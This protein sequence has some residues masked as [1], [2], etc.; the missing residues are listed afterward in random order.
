MN[1]TNK[2]IC[3]HGHFYQPPRENAWLEVVELQD[4][5]QPFHDWNDRINFECYAPN[6]AARILDEK[7]FIKK[8]INNYTRISFNFG[9]TLLSWMEKADPETYREILKADQIS[10]TKFSGHGSAIAQVHSHLILPLANRADK[11]TQVIWGIKDFE[12]RFGRKPE[13]MWLAETAANLESLEVL[14]ENDIRYTILSPR[15]AKSIRKIGSSKWKDGLDTRRPYLVKL[16]SGKTMIVFFYDGS[17]AQ[18]V[19]FDG[20]LNNGKGFASRFINTFDDDDTPQLAHVATDGESY[21]HHHRYGEMALADCIDYIEKNNLAT[22][23]NY[24]EY[25]DK[26]PVEYEALMHENS[27]WS[28]VHG[29]ERWRND[30][31]CSSGGNAGWNQK[32]RAPLRDVLDWLRDELIPIFENEGGKLLND[33]WAARNDYISIILNRKEENIEAFIEQHAKK[34]L[35]KKEKTRLMRILEMQRNAILM[36]SSCGWFFDEIS[37][38]ETNQILQYALRAISYNKQLTGVDLHGEFLNQ[39]RKAPSNVYENGAVSYEKHI[40]PTQLNLERVAMHYA[41]ASLFAENP[42]KLSLFNYVASS[43]HFVKEEGGNLIMTMGR[44]KMKSRVTLSE[45]HFSFAVLY[46]GQQNLIGYISVDMNEK[47]FREM[48]DKMIE[49]FR[50]TNL[51]D[52]LGVMQHYFPENKFTVWHLFRDEKRRILKKITQKSLDQMDLIFEDIYKGNYQ[53]MSGMQQSNIPIPEPYQ[54]ATQHVINTDLHKFF[55]KTHLDVR[56][57]ERLSKEMKKWELE[58]NNKQDFLLTAS[59]RIFYEVKM[60]SSA[61]VSIE[62]IET[63]NSILRIFKKMNFK[64][65]IWKS[66]NLYFSMLKG[67]KNQDWVFANE[68]WKDAFMEL[69]ELLELE[70]M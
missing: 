2:Y 35:S 33:V 12:H 10:Q 15:Q 63:L 28:C 36:F 50:S 48:E 24:G 56:E 51:G 34:T 27:S 8:I 59:E 23:T 1:S 53:L 43:E 25:L 60:I 5:A 67:F 3:I 22:I 30:C 52:V 26:F 41:A 19:A 18:G 9:P 46:L 21:G 32:W 16:P 31:G 47:T 39:L 14:A 49:A 17:I 4:S 20:L 29:I 44:T 69:G 55:E 45:K 11:E 7:Q 38:I 62:H 57:L 6:T 54:N 37:G 58:L 70:L 13:G 40:V 61:E 42:E 66:Q 68:K 65:N 64:P